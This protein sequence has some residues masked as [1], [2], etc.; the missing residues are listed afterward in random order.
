[1]KTLTIPSLL[2]VLSAFPAAAA[3]YIGPA[4][5]AYGDGANWD[6]AAVP[7]TAT[8]ESAVIGNGATVD[9]NG[10]TL[11]DLNVNGGGSLTVSGGSTLTTGQTNWSQI[12]NGTFT[13]NGGTFSRTAV[14][15]LVG[16]QVAG[17]AGSPTTSVLNVT[18]G[19]TISMQAAGASNLILGFTNFTKSTM[20]LTNSTVNLAGELWLGS[21]TTTDS[22][23]TAELNI[24]NS[25]ITTGGAVGLWIWD[26]AATGNSMK[27]NFS[28]PAGSYIHAIN[29]IG[30]RAN[31][32]AA[33]NATTWESLWALGILTAE[34]QSGLTG[35]SFGTYFVTSG[36]AIRD[37]PTIVDYRLTYV[38]EPSG[39]ML[40]GLTGALL[41]GRRR[42]S[43]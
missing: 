41:L 7:A 40:A 8:G 16:S 37:T 9:Y 34:G 29:S 43:A 12:N 18:N 27:I 2:L 10:T 26:Y 23:Q 15:N 28:G 22:N 35:A 30:S 11:L 39:A 17:T 4:A 1:M 42:R 25:S 19:S 5:G 14:G 3:T 13:L 36:T 33:N 6:T 24:Y 32:T 38:P 20:N 31:A 21:N